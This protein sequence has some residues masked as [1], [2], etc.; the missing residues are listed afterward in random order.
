MG[1]RDRFGFFSYCQVLCGCGTVVGPQL[2][3]AHDLCVTAGKA[4]LLHSCEGS[5]FKVAT[6]M[7]SPVCWFGDCLAYASI[8]C[9][10]RGHFQTLLPLSGFPL[11]CQVWNRIWF[12]ELLV[13][14]LCVAKD[15]SLSFI[16]SCSFETRCFGGQ[17]FSGVFIYRHICYIYI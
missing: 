15:S 14:F 8:L 6:H 2:L 10:L 7:T 17:V 9:D 12:S 13:C 11:M 3:E 16:S 1:N 4:T 5:V